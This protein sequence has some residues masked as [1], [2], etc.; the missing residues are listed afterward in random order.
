MSLIRSVIHS[1]CIPT[2][3]P[4]TDPFTNQLILKASP[5]C[6]IRLSRQVLSRER[7]RTTTLVWR[8]QRQTRW[9]ATRPSI[10]FPL[11]THWTSWALRACQVRMVVWAGRH[12]RPSQTWINL[13]T[14]IKQ[15]WKWFFLGYIPLWV[16]GFSTTLY[17][18]NTHYNYWNKNNA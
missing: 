12:I 2:T 11:V 15:V 10:T 18:V 3:Q 13:W 5:N 14:W 8:R 17:K 6:A 4:T 9:R 1:P 16:S 7:K